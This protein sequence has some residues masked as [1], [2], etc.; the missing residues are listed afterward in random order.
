MATQYAISYC[1]T[2]FNQTK[3]HLSEIIEVYSKCLKS[4]Y[5]TVIHKPYGIGNRNTTIYVKIQQCTWS[6]HIT[7][8]TFDTLK[9]L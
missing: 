9:A 4:V 6:F 7:T 3:T 8:F 1:C 5:Y 2:A